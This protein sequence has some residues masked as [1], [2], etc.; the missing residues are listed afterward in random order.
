M[1]VPDDPVLESAPVVAEGDGQRP[2]PNGI[3]ARTVAQSRRNARRTP[4]SGVPS[5]S[6][7][8]PTKRIPGVCPSK[9]QN[10]HEVDRDGDEAGE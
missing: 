9:A 2:G 5:C 10:A 1:S 6:S 7:W 4:I 8:M 3:T